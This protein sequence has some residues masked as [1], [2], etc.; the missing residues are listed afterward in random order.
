MKE[1]GARVT[2]PIGIQFRADTYRSSGPGAQEW[3]SIGG[4]T[5]IE[6][7]R[8][9]DIIDPVD[10]ELAVA[11]PAGSQ[12]TVSGGDW[13]Q[14]E[15][16][17]GQPLEFRHTASLQSETVSIMVSTNAPNIAGITDAR[18]DVRGSVTGLTVFDSTLAQQIKE[19]D[20]RIPSD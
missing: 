16:S 9:D 12:L 8:Y 4:S 7:R 11:I 1:T 20:L 6:F 10:I 14:T 13:E 15:Q 19:G 2:R 5:I 17:D 18:P 3:G